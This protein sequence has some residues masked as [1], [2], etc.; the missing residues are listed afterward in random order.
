MEHTPTFEISAKIIQ[1]FYAHSQNAEGLPEH[2]ESGI[3]AVLKLSPIYF[4]NVWAT[5]SFPSQSLEKF[6][7][8]A[9]LQPSGTVDKLE[10]GLI[11]FAKSLPSVEG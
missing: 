4:F 6:D 8:I 7:L 10:E 3:R 11:A 1:A 9:K 2:M 5:K